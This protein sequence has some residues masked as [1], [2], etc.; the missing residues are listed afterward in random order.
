MQ[1]LSPEIKGS[2]VLILGYGRE[3]Q[4]VHRY[5]CTHAPQIK[6]AVSDRQ[7]VELIAEAALDTEMFIGD[8]EL[9]G[10]KN[11]DTIIR[12]PGISPLKL[13]ELSGRQVTTLTNIFMSLAP[14]KVIG[15]TGTKGKSTTA[16]LIH[17]MLGAHFADVRL[18]GNIGLPALDY[19]DGADENSVFVIELSSF[20]LE[21]LH[22]SPD[23]AVLL[24]IFPEHLDHHGTF[25]NYISAKLNIFKRQQQVH[26]AVLNLDAD[27][28]VSG[29]CAI[30]SRKCLYSLRNVDAACCFVR[31]E[32]ICLRERDKVVSVMPLADLPL[33]GVGNVKNTL[34]AATTAHLLGVRAKI[35][36]QAV[37]DFSPLEHR[38]EYVGQHRGIHFYNDSLSTIPQAAI[39]AL[40]ALG[41]DVETIILG[42]HDRG[43]DYSALGPAIVESKI[44]T[45]IL[46]PSTGERI[47]EVICS[48]GKDKE[49][50]PT[51]FVTESMEEAVRIAYQHTSANKICLLSP[52]SSSLNLFRDYRE[53]GEEFRKW[54]RELG[55]TSL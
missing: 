32:S 7:P 4:C 13:K 48:A 38:L 20:Q 12:S 21:D 22:Y 2:S 19:L 47:W 33:L 11:Y 9:S 34:A 31:E 39:N 26:Y 52:A 3:G 43:I 6:V 50:L 54:V 35:I 15:V 24:E 37:R 17:G 30:N 41:A 25:D 36:A 45:V 1:Q 51:K 10:F 55:I 42:G 46:F 53:R 5:L 40:E 27:V 44:K 18:V 28:F 49:T 8:G 29:R 14:G 23:V 16:S